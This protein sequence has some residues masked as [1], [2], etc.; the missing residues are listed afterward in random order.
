MPTI[1]KDDFILLT[2]DG[3]PTD[4]VLDYI[5]RYDFSKSSVEDLLVLIKDIWWMPEWGVVRKGRK[6]E[7]H[8]GGW[9]GNEDLVHAL[10]GNFLFWSLCWRK[11]LAGGHF[12]F[13]IPKS[14]K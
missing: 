3:Y 13:S 5:R 12:Y 7:L 11:S 6:S 2:S 4:E 14:L 10:E 9:S 1:K 8:T